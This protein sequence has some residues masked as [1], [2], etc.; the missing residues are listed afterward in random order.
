MNVTI[1]HSGDI[2]KRENKS[3]QMT[4]QYNILILNSYV[5][6]SLRAKKEQ[7]T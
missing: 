5:D 2:I 1:Y 6:Y 4:F 7:K 3:F